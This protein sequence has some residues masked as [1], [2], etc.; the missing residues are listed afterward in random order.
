MLS[1]KHQKEIITCIYEQFIK[2][3]REQQKKLYRLACLILGKKINR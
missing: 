3:D 2:S 1:Q